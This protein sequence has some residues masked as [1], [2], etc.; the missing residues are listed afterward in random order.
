MKAKKGFFH[1]TFAEL[2]KVKWPSTKEVT[3]NTLST[4][5]F[6]V[7]FGVFFYLVDIA[8]AWLVGVLG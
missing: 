3:K 4:I 6:C 5:V 8:F 2:K 1:S 7:F